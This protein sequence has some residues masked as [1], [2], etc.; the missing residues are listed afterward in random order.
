MAISTNREKKNAMPA[1]LTLHNIDD[2][3][4]AK[5]FR[6]LREAGRP[7]PINDIWLADQALEH[8]ASSSRATVISGRSPICRR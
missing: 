8:G 4:Y 5:V 3:F 1:A 6:S 7:I 2:E